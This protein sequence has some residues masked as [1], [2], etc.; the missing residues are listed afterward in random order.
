[1]VRLG[2]REI[3][4]LNTLCPGGLARNVDLSAISQWR[5][6]GN[7]D[8]II[9][10]ASTQQISDVIKWFIGER[11][12]P[13]VIGLTS[14]LL[15]SDEGIKTPI[16]QIGNRMAKMKIEGVEVLAQAGV[17]V[18]GLA[19]C[20]MKAELTGAE[21][22]CGIPGTLGGLVY[23][24]GGSQ[25][26]C[27]GSNIVSVESVDAN[28]NIC[29]RVAEKCNFAYRKSLFQTNSEII[30]RVNMRFKKGERLAIRSDMLSILADRGRKFPRKLPNC[31]SVFKSDPAMYSEIGP[32]GAAIER[33][34]LKGYSIGAAQVSPSHANFIVNNG[35]AS[36]KEVLALIHLVST[37]VEK[38]M[39]YK[40]MPEVIY[41]S[42]NGVMHEIDKYGRM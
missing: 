7:A 9:R 4:H 32:P 3:N 10:P 19:R 11:I 14:N 36:A 21:H 28:G 16:I 12:K 17:W 25:R 35:G 42:S 8:L 15:F 27:I 38:E 23:M 39:G 26:K 40:M 20:L 22:I 30:T 37:T 6:G 2:E 18:P 34:G 5:I 29:V 24:N 1:M 31:G 41:V 13:V 33:I